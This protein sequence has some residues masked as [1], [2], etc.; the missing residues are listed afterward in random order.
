MSEAYLTT[1][2]IGNIFAEEIEDQSGQVTDTFDDGL[3]LLRSCSVVQV[4]KS[5][6]VYLC[7]QD[8]KIFPNPL[9]IQRL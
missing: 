1:S 5:L 2:T 3:R 6:A 4:N 8:G 7:L 9:D